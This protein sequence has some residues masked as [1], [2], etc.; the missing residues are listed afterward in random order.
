[1]STFGRSGLV[2]SRSKNLFA[3]G[4]LTFPFGIFPFIF[5][6]PF[7]Q[8]AISDARSAILVYITFSTFV[9]LII[10]RTNSPYNA[11]NVIKTFALVN[12]RWCNTSN[13]L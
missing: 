10:G 13:G 3:P 9:L 2:L 8:P 12:L 6:S 7:F 4:K 1:M 5:P 11:S